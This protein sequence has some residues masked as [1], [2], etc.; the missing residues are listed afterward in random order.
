M[1][2]LISTCA[3]TVIKIPWDA[4]M[5]AMHALVKTWNTHPTLQRA[6]KD[7]TLTNVSANLHTMPMTAMNAFWPTNAVKTAISGRKIVV[8]Q[9]RRWLLVS[10]RTKREC[11]Q[12]LMGEIMSQRVYRT[13]HSERNCTMSITLHLEDPPTN[14]SWIFATARAAICA[15]SAAFVWRKTIVWSHAASNHVRSAP[16]QMRFATNVGV[17]A[18]PAPAKIKIPKWNATEAMTKPIAINAIASLTIIA[19]TVADAY[20]WTNARKTNKMYASAPIHVTKIK[21]S[22]AST[23]VLWKRVPRQ[24]ILPEDALKNAT[25]H[26]NA[27]AAHT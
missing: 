25:T 17:N 6:V 24:W 21:R 23:H 2:D 19:M 8:H 15:T 27:K 20:R 7:A 22:R 3:V 13:H 9:T 14:A 4:Q 1:R 18:M 5:I 26:A 12:M 11:A 10:S 16:I